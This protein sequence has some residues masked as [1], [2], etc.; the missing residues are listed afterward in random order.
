M[1]QLT[2]KH[3]EHDIAQHCGQ[4]YYCE[5]CKVYFVMP[6]EDQALDMI[7]KEVFGESG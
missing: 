5:D 3:I 6:T 2:L 1:I 7:A 4:D